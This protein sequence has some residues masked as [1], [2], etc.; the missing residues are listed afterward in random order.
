M[1]SRY[2]VVKTAAPPNSQFCI[3][4]ITRCLYLA[5]ETTDLDLGHEQ[6]A[7]VCIVATDTSGSPKVGER[8]VYDK[9]NLE[10]LPI[11]TT[12]ELVT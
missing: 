6:Q 10:Y 8:H 2:K 11:G 12:I 5:V 7:V 9:S 4:R 3:G 1:A